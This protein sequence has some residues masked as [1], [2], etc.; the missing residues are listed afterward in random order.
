[1]V[2][3]EI[4][5]SA[6]GVETTYYQGI[7]CCLVLLVV[8]ELPAWNPDLPH[9]SRESQLGKFVTPTVLPARLSH[10]ARHPQTFFKNLQFLL[11]NGAELVCE[12]TASRLAFA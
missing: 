5:H 7:H 10:S 9:G 11:E 2:R 6:E 12:I 1:M 4:D 8:G 3:A